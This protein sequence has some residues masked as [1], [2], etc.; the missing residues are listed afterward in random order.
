MRPDSPQPLPPAAY[1]QGSPLLTPPDPP[2][3][4]GPLVFHL[5]VRE[6]HSQNTGGTFF[7]PFYELG[8]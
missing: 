2:G 8:P 1:A 7:R 6:S 3:D 4:T 5:Y